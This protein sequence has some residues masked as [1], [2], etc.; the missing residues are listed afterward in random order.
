M[1]GST[2]SPQ[3]DHLTRAT[4]P[5]CHETAPH[6]PRR[7]FAALRRAAGRLVRPRAGFG[8]RVEG[9]SPPPPSVPAV[10]RPRPGEVSR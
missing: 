7:A 3:R 5:P 1:P 10:E 2:R 4:D 8:T 6:D 9:V